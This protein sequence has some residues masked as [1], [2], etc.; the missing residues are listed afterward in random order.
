MKTKERI[1]KCSSGLLFI[2]LI[3]MA[4][5]KVVSDYE[6]SSSFKGVWNRTSGSKTTAIAIGCIAKNESNFIYMCEWDTPYPDNYYGTIDESTGQITWEF[7]FEYTQY[8]YKAEVT[9]SALNLYAF[10]EGVYVSAGSYVAGSWPGNHCNVIQSG[11]SVMRMN[12]IIGNWVRHTTTDYAGIVRNYTWHWAISEGGSW[13]WNCYNDTGGYLEFS[14][15]GT[16]FASGNTLTI[17]EPPNA[18]NGNNEITRT[19]TYTVSETQLTLSNELYVWKGTW[20]RE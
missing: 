18:S 2:S 17:N 3:L 13:T 11:D 4:N 7:P 1:L 5:C 10:V 15:S 9:G 20:N 14:S 19:G 8:M 16:W 6:A 12:T